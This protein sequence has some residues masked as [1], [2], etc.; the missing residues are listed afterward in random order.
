M[1]T[2]EE[3]LIHLYAVAFILTLYTWHLQGDVKMSFNEM[4]M[5]VEGGRYFVVIVLLYV[6]T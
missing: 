3:L 4:I 5:M 2:N 6:L 1:R